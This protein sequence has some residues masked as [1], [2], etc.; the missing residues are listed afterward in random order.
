[1]KIAFLF[2]GQGAQKQNMGKSFY[3]NDA[4]SRAVFDSVKTVTGID[5]CDLIFKEN[6]ELNNTRYTQIAMVATGIAMLKAVEKTGLK[7]DICAGLSLGE[8]E[9]LYLSGAISAK[10]AIA[11][12]DKRGQYMSEIKGGAM[13][14]VLSLD[15]DTIKSVVDDIDGCW[16]ANYNCPGQ[17][18]ISGTKEA[19]ALAGEKLKEA[20]AKRVLPLKVSGAFHS[21]LMKEAGEKLAKVLDEIKINDIQIPYVANVNAQI[22]TDKNDIKKNLIEQVSGSV[23]LEQSIR[24]MIEWGVDTFVEVGPGKTMAGFVKKIDSQV[25]MYNIEEYADVANVCSQILEAR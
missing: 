20:G 21:G 5:A 3:E 12:V 7:A 2:P 8:Y 11:T 14:A 18:V 1:M 15:N 19:V 17:T 23:H 6:D 13:S 10:D 22:V 9:A 16:V 24:K 25:K 4:D